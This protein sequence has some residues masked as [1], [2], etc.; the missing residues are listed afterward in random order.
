VR[1]F[2]INGRF[3]TQEATG[4][5]R[6]AEEVV[7]TLDAMV[8]ADEIDSHK[9]RFTVLAPRCLSRTLDLKHINLKRVGRCSGL[10]WEQVE[11]PWYARGGHLINLCN[12]APMIRR[13]QTVTIHDAGI[14]AMPDSYS[15]AFRIWYRFLLTV[16]GRVSKRVLTDSEFSRHE[17]GRYL[18]ISPTKIEA[19]PLG[20]EHIDTISA[21]DYIIERAGLSD[22]PYLL[23]VGSLSARKNFEAILGAIDR[24]GKVDFNIVIA[25]GT[26]PKVFGDMKVKL[27]NYVYHLGYVTDGELKS[28]YRH[29]TAFIY[30]SLYEGFGLPPLEAM[31]C[32][33]PAIVSDIPPHR[34]VCGEAALYCNP[35]DVDDMAGKIQLIM[36]DE[37]LRRRLA[38]AGREQEKK[39]SWKTTARNF[40]RVLERDYS[41]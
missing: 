31:T 32:G 36:N 18:H 15:T 4:V 39:F 9:V 7:K 28:L 30:P 25:G 27:P 14:F 38:A 34:E 41:H 37:S 23:A 13:N 20:R 26:N 33:C 8:G 24:S 11:L 22:K 2:Y 12:A 17:L 10:L 5:Q 19:I 6:Y 1:I 16:L 35:H 29:A 3:L 40:L 21:E